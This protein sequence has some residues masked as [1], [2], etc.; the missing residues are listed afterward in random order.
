MN[1]LLLSLTLLISFQLETEKEF[2]LIKHIGWSDKPII[3]IFISKNEVETDILSE[4]FIVEESLYKS[5]SDSVSIF[6]KEN[7][8]KEDIY[9]FGTF[10]L[11][12]LNRDAN[13][14][15]CRLD[16]KSTKILLEAFSRSIDSHKG[17][18]ELLKEI[19]KVQ[20][21]ISIE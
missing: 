16:W 10:E 20:R 21:R 1:K 13:A 9:E 7:S 2:I 19:Q 17:N 5:L 11:V 8:L 12:K 15:I 6:C 3:S 18:D 4:N 14:E